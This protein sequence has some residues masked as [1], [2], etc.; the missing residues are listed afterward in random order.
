[1]IRRL[2]ACT[3]AVALVAAAPAAALVSAVIGANNPIEL[4]APVAAG[5]QYA[6]PQVLVVNTGSRPA[7][8]HVAV[9]RLTKAGHDIPAAWITFARNDV[10]LRPKQRANI[11][12]TLRV[13][14]GTPAGLYQSDVVASTVSPHGIEAKG[15]GAAAATIL[16]FTVKHRGGE[17]SLWIASVAG[18][19]LA[20]LVAGWALRHAGYEIAFD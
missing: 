11:A 8:F 10:P 13:P 20:L 16:R 12:V 18:G 5:A 6:M 14:H 19:V 15:V 4:A 1:M 9:D 7:R 3:A 2:L 17:D